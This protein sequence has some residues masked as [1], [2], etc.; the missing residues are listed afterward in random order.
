MTVAPALLP[1][2]TLSLSAPVLEMLTVVNCHPL[3][4]GVL[5][6]CLPSPC[7]PTAWL[8]ATKMSLAT[9][10]WHTVCTRGLD[11]QHAPWAVLAGGKGQCGWRRTVCSREG[12]VQ[13]AHYAVLVWCKGQCGRQRRVL[14]DSQGI[15]CFWFETAM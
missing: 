6:I 9:C 13:F 11:V 7:S 1:V 4:P 3:D 5:L 15:L 10:Q 8:S 14:N 2:A 12:V